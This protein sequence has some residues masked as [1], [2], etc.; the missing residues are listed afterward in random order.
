LSGIDEGD[1]ALAVE[2]PHERDLPAQ[3]GHLPSCQTISLL[4]AQM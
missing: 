1:G 2:P 3:S 4:I